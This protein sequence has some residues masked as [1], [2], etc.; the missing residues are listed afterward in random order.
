[1]VVVDV[2]SKRPPLAR[3]LQIRALNAALNRPLGEQLFAYLAN[4]FQSDVFSVKFSAPVW[5]VIGPYLY[6][7]RDWEVLR[8]CYPHVAEQVLQT[9]LRYYE[10]YPEEIDVRIERNNRP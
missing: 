2:L 6:A 7:D 10:A 3:P 1:M 4:P 9:A 5:E 8:Q